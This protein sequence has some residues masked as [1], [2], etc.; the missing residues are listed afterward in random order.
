MK[1]FGI[2]AAVFLVLIDS[3]FQDS[4][5]MADFI[6]EQAAKG[7]DTIICQCEHGQSRSAGAAAAIEEFFN[8]SGIS[9]FA[10]YRYC[11]NQI[12]YNKLIKALT[13]QNLLRAIKRQD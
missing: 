11:P 5:K 6:L 8:K 13:T 7:I 1:R 3:F 4:V 12:I 10:E 9:V 2:F